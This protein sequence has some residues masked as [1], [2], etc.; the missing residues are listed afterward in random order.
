MIVGSTKES[1]KIAD[2]I[3]FFR[4]VSIIDDEYDQL[5]KEF[6][7]QLVEYQLTR[8]R[9][10]NY[11]GCTNYATIRAWCTERVNRLNTHS[12]PKRKPSGSF[13]NFEQR[14]YDYDTLEKQLLSH[15]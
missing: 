13:Y 10:N 6:G 15:S 8:I 9:D 5:V 4:K 2:T 12:A 7:K 11:R 3:I 1:G 14:N